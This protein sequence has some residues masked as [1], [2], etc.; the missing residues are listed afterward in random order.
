MR[1]K[2][3]QVAVAFTALTAVIALCILANEQLN[4]SQSRLNLLGAP[5]LN[6]AMMAAE[7]HVEASQAQDAK[8]MSYV[9][10]FEKEDAARAK[11]D[12]EKHP[13]A[14]AAAAA[15]APAA[16]P[17]APAAAAAPAAPAP[18]P[19]AGWSAG[20]KLKL[21]APAVVKRAPA[22]LQPK[23]RTVDSVRPAGPSVTTQP[24]ELS[25]SAI[26]ES[27]LLKEKFVD[28][29][30][31]ARPNDYEKY[32][33]ERAKK[34]AERH[35][36]RELAREEEERKR[37][38]A[39]WRQ[40]RED[41]E[42]DGPDPYRPPSPPRAQV[43]LKLSGEEAFLRR[44]QMSGG[45]GRGVPP[46]ESLGKRPEPEGGAAGNPALKMMAKMGWSG[47]GLGKDEQGI[48][49]AIVPGK[50]TPSSVI[51]L[52]NMVGRGQ[53]DPELQSETAQECSKYGP[54]ESCKI[55]EVA[56]PS[57]SDTHAVRIFVKFGRHESAEKAL[58]DMNGRFFGGRNVR[59]TL[60]SQERFNQGDL[61]PRPD[62]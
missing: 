5:A 23:R 19:A 33:E 2:T 4:Q 47:G 35:R 39:A 10:F 56:D 31:P 16:A 54:V 60:F 28:E 15:P 30:D 12:H 40:A 55:V 11:N 18:A 17:A 38:L 25:S 24:D 37:E 7:S 1:R 48:T 57:V 34:E 13:S 51:L 43:N 20:S 9:H 8:A 6:Q 62:E 22:P 21:M 45:R 42:G 32:I 14:L 44:A 59:A 52:S 61:Q 26:E 3:V 46:P 36:E 29:Y 58:A 49:T 50:A 53:V 27:R 41:D